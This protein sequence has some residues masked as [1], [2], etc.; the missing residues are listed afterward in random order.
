MPSIGTALVIP[1]DR[2]SWV[3]NSYVLA[4]GGFLLLGGR[5]A[6]FLGRRR[7]SGAGTA[8][9]TIASPRYNPGAGRRSVRITM[10]SGPALS[11]T[12]IRQ[13]GDHREDAGRPHGR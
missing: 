2:L 10:G 7:M 4:F 11:R 3:V 12:H 6:D 1:Q 8:L 13:R 9:F 5:L